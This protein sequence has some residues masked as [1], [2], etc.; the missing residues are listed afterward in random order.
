V[1]DA[2][3]PA[4]DTQRDANRKPAEALSFAGVKPGDQIGELIPGRGYFTKLF[5]KI[6]GDQGHVYTVGIRP[7]MRPGAG[8]PPSDMPG[9]RAGGAPPA[10]PGAGGPPA[11]A[12]PSAG[13]PCTNV[14]ASNGT[15]DEFKLPPNLD[16]VWTSENYHDLAS[17]GFAVDMAVINGKIFAAL[18]PGGVY[19][20]EDHAAAPGSGTRD[21]STLHRVDKGAVVSAVTA[22]GFKL[23]AESALLANAA[24][25]HSKPSRE[26]D[27]ASDKFLLKFRKPAK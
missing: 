26:L 22:A 12:A 5:C 3:R 23:E 14:T 8:A 21:T 17:P 18:K 24:D 10:G 15:P 20:V 4:T 19:M 2:T 13:T 11:Q 7:T 6:V 27:G 1:A 16:V 9:A 25:D